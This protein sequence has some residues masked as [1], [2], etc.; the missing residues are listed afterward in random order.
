MTN[1]GGYKNLIVYQ[2]AVVIFDLTDE[3][4]KRYMTYMSNKSYRTYDQMIQA[5]RSGKQN[6]V[7]GMGQE[8]YLLSKQIQ[9]A[10][11]KFVKE[12]GFNE[13][14]AKKRREFRGY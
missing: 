11:E 6:I 7:E 9:A 5:S 8:T 12:G 14:L 3:F 13:N 1:T 10:E 2:Q 4:C